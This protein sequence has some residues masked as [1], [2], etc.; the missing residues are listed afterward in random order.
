MLIIQRIDTDRETL[1]RFQESIN[2]ENKVVIDA[3]NSAKKKLV[4]VSDESDLKV[5]EELS[6]E[7]V[8]SK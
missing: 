6:P 3:Y 7:Q 4:N 8:L 5:V 2:D 1:N